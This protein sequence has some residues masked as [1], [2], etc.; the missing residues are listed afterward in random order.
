MSAQHNFAWHR[1]R[2]LRMGIAFAHV[3]VATTPARFP[4]LFDFFSRWE[5]PRLRETGDGFYLTFPR[6]EGNR[7]AR[8]GSGVCSQWTSGPRGRKSLLP[9]GKLRRSARRVARNAPLSAPFAPQRRPGF[10]R[11][12]SRRRRARRFRNSLRRRTAGKAAAGC[13]E[14]KK[15]RAVENGRTGGQAGPTRVNVCRCDR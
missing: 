7:P 13:D 3:L 8:G 5:N 4:I 2:T 14:G 15:A 6:R 12:L 1:K 10:G 9:F 11:S